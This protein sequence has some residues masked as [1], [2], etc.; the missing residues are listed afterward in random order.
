MSS[1]D[2][3]ELAQLRH[4]WGDAYSILHNSDGWQAKRKD[5]RGDWIIRPTVDELYRAISADYTARP[6]PRQDGQS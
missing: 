5:R 1:Y 6:V 2:D 3:D 4:H